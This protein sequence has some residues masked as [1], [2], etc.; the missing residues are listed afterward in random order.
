MT[1][2]FTRCMRAMT[3]ARSSARLG[4]SRVI[5][6]A[7]ALAASLTAPLLAQPAPESKVPIAW[8]RYYDHAEMTDLLNQLVAAY[9]NL[10]SIESIGKSEQG[11]ELWMVT[12]NNPMTGPVEDKPAMYIDGNVHGNEVQA[13]ETVLYSLWYLVSAHGS[14]PAI[15]ELCNRSVFHF[16]PSVNP[17]GRDAWMHTPT[18]PS[19][20]RSGLRP[21]D[22]DGDGL[23]DEDGPDDLDGDGHIGVMWRPDPNGTHRRDRDDPRLFVRVT[24]P[25][26]GDWSFAGSEGIDNDGDGQSNEDGPGGYD[27]NRNWPTDWRPDWIQ[28]GA[29][30]HPF[31]YPETDAVGR[32]LL[33]HPAVAAGQSYHNTGGMILRGPGA[34]YRTGDFPRAD[35][36]VYDEIANAG[37]EMLPF[38]RSMI[39]YADLYTV[40]G[41]FI[42]WISEGLGIVSFTNE[43]WTD[44]RILQT[45]E[46]PAD[47]KAR[48]RWAD[49]M[50]FGQTL[51]EWKTVD[52]PEFGEVLVGGSNKWASRTP[53][54]FMLEE[55]CH[56]N[57]AFTMFHAQQMPRLEWER[58]EVRKLGD[59]L[60]EVTIEVGNSGLIPSRT[61]R[62]AER[63]IGMPDVVTVTGEGIRVA[64]AGTLGRF[65]DRSMTPVAHR[66]ERMTLE[67]G[68]PGRG[69]VVLR[70]LI[71]GDEGRT[72]T[73]RCAAE[74][75]TDIETTVELRETPAPSTPS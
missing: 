2:P 10:L 50:L 48:M 43:L 7:A 21:T 62:A 57:F 31:S 29:G 28:G 70:F 37:V 20:Y 33:A 67:A 32:W 34:S 24:P 25:A 12:M 72:M 68:V 49:R 71:E 4:C 65:T 16:L 5:A 75:A 73:I 36:A 27:M 60:W 3:L 1:T 63:K 44:Q 64:T 74:K 40:H 58:R 15:T 54:S 41:G 51:S 46:A 66:P 18:N 6:I 35:I 38:Y 69:R 30:D 26:R 13:T 22:S 14:V 53:P 39:L 17:D 19:N 59:R 42:N 56:R 52:H 61:A 47:E 9:P 45:G 55:E 11:R 23:L 8:N